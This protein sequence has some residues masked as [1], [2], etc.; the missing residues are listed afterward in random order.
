MDIEAEPFTQGHFNST[1][2]SDYHNDDAL[3]TGIIIGVGALI[4]IGCLFKCFCKTSQAPRV[5]PWV[6]PG[7]NN[8]DV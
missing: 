2:D 6:N 1:T 8:P 4:L 7:I 5:L 3:S